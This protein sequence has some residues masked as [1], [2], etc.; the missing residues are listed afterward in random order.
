MKAKLLSRSVVLFV[1]GIAM[2]IWGYRMQQR[3][4]L[5]GHDA[6][7]AEQQQR[8]DRTYTH[9][10]H[11]LTEVIVGLFLAILIFGFY[12]LLVFALSRL[13]GLGSA[14]DRRS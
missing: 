14:N 7:I 12:E 13:F 8:W 1:A 10:H 2:G 4:Y 6:F 9:P 5:Q 11:L 3:H